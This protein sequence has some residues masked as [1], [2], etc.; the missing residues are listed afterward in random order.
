M[1]SCK[2]VQEGSAFPQ[3]GSLSCAKGSTAQL[4]PRPAAGPAV[5][6]AGAAGLETVPGDGILVSQHSFK[7][8][9][10]PL[11]RK[12]EQQQQKPGTF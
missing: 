6:E 8:C 1:G 4:P 5:L 2:P 7:V 10:L 12:K 9:C 11:P 3:A